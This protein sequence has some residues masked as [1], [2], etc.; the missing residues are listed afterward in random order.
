LISLNASCIVPME[1]A[2]NH[3]GIARKCTAVAAN[4]YL[5]PRRAHSPR[6]L[7]RTLIDVDLRASHVANECIMVV[8]R[9]CGEA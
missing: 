9:S 6:T 7:L 1:E 5:R 2:P 3:S 8:M 4:L